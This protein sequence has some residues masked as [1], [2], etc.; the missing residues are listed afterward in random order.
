[1]NRTKVS[2][3]CDIAAENYLLRAKLLSSGVLV[4]SVAGVASPTWTV[5]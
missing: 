1:M 4:A 3:S 2:L 5:K